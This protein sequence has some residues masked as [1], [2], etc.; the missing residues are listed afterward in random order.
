MKKLICSTICL[1][2]VLLLFVIFPSEIKWI[3]GDKGV[4]L[5][6][7]I[8]YSLVYCTFIFIIK[9]SWWIAKIF[10]GFTNRNK[11]KAMTIYEWT[12]FTRNIEKEIKQ[13]IGDEAISGKDVVNNLDIIKGRVV[14]YFNKDINRMKTFKAYLKVVTED[15][16]ATT[17]KTFILGMLSTGFVSLIIQNKM[18]KVMLFDYKLKA[19]VGSAFYYGVGGLF[20][21]VV[22]I[23]IITSLLIYSDRTRERL[24]V[25]CIDMCIDEINSK[26]KEESK[27]EE[28]QEES[29][30]EEGKL[31]DK[32]KKGRNRRRRKRKTAQ[33]A[34]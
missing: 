22:I 6:M 4:H 16:T 25:E 30:V 31:D 14:T 32:E 8:M 2:I 1:A 10:T 19:E 12:K 18:D 26:E 34:I 15:T 21:W 5:L 23:S 3:F 24:L 11:H 13:I 27:E 17:F 20:I 7:I 33:T 29:K 28:E 9:F